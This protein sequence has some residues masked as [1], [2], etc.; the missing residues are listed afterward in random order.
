MELMDSNSTQKLT[1]SER[2]H[3]IVVLV[4]VVREKIINYYYGVL[5]DILQNKYVGES[6]KRC[7]LLSCEWFDPTLNRGT[8]SHKLSKLIEVHRTWRY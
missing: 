3:I 8:R 2:K 5:K 6:L 4:Y 1:V 7:V